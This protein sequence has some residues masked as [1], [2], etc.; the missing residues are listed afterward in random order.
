M[1]LRIGEQGLLKV[2]RN[3][4]GIAMDQVG[5][6]HW[7]GGRDGGAGVERNGYGLVLDRG[8][9]SLS[10]S[11]LTVGAEIPGLRRPSLP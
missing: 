6:V 7:V 2:G 4:G 8:L 9:K 1:G 3:S 10:R 11:K 5:D